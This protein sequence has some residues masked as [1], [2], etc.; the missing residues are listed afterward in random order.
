MTRHR[1]HVLLALLLAVTLAWQPARADDAVAVELVGKALM[2]QGKPKLLVRI[3]APVANVDLEL[4]RS[5]GVRIAK[6]LKRPRPGSTGEFVLDQP[7]GAFHYDGKLTVG[8][9]KGPPREMPLSF[10]TA[11]FGPPKLT[12]RDDAVNLDARTVTVA[13]ERDGA[14]VQWK[15]VGDDGSTL[16]D[17]RRNITGHKAGEP[18][19]LTWEAR[20]GA[21]ALRISVRAT[22]IHGFYQELELFPWRVEIPHE[23][24]LFDSGRSEI[25]DAERPK[26]DA[27]FGELAKA[28]ERYGKLVKV[29]LFIAGFT[30]TVGDASSNQALSQARALSIARYFRQKGARMPIHYV[31]Y[32]EAGLLVPTPDET[33]EAKNRRATYT[34]AAESPRGGG[35]SKLP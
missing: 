23:D 15:V 6:S 7:E 35:W 18:I 2:G 31:G 5:D 11:C 22:D 24:V 9:P 26:L 13:F 4:V 1:P 12:A 34:I 19:Q 10:D 16:S 3:Q 29:Q 28:V 33:A 8:F 32:G 27:A 21:S 20:P 17:E 25:V 30:D 14:E